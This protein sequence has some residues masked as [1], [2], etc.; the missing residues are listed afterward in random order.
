MAAV[1]E[2]IAE[3]RPGW[4]ELERLLLRAGQN[5]R[6][7]EAVDL[8]RLGQL[9]R[10]V[11]ADLAAARRDFPREQV[12]RY[13]ND[14]A[15]RAYPTLYRA[16]AGA[17]RRLGQFFLEEF[18]A[19]FRASG[20]FMAASFLLFALPALAGYLVAVS[21]PPAAEPLLPL[22][23]TESLR[24]GELWTSISEARRSVASSAIMTNNLR[25]A[26]LAFAGGVLFGALTV[27]VMVLNGL[28]MGAVFGY[29]QSFGLGAELAAFVSPHGYLELSV[30]FIAGGA[31]LQMGWA[32]LC[33]GLLRR[34]DALAR[35][36][37]HAVRLLIGSA[38][39]LVIAG[40]IEGFVSPSGL[41][42][43]AKYWF[44]LF[45]GLLLYLFLLW[46][47]LLQRW[48]RWQLQRRPRSL[49]SR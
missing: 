20:P 6:R 36:A 30:V 10:H 43:W 5:P 14:L 22:S 34:R 26:A 16:P 23:V 24:R 37:E 47:P 33:P 41:P 3:H 35:A 7:L 18:P 21:N 4:T 32:L 2:F 49:S 27:Y 48:R 39:L 12:T 40:L 9:Y 25:V 46:P 19:R 15:A 17:W 13:L 44:G 11:A 31:G 28:S 42:A 29:T 38:P 8:E 1:D 45:T